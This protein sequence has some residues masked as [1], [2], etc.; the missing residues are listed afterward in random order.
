MKHLYSFEKS[1]KINENIEYKQIN[2]E[3]PTDVEHLNLQLS[4]NE[5]RIEHSEE[6]PKN[7]SHSVHRFVVLL[8][9]ES[10]CG[11]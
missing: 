1:I 6:L 9:Q 8:D 11:I 10:V 5:W 4:A 3:V 2:R 7:V